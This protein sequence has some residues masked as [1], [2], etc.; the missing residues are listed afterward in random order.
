MKK[1]YILLLSLILLI[2]ST[3]VNWTIQPEGKYIGEGT[4]IKSNSSTIEIL[5]EQVIYAVGTVLCKKT[6]KEAYA[7]YLIDDSNIVII[8]IE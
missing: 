3:C 4:V 7:F 6:K 2:I 1:R 5:A 8:E